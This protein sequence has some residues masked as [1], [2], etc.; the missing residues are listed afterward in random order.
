[1]DAAEV[2]LTALEAG[3]GGG[4]VTAPS[5]TGIVYL[6]ASY[7][8]ENGASDGSLLKPYTN[9]GTAMTAKLTEGATTNYTFQLAPGSYTGAISIDRNTAT[10]S[11]TIQGSGPDCTFV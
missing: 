10:Q 5:A 11:F 7:G 3:G 1:M 8:A 2:R 4:G 6:D 9:L